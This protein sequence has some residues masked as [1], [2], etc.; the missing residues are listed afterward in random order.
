MS[1]EDDATKSVQGVPVLSIIIPVLNEEDNVAPLFERLDKTLRALANDYEVI[2][3][4]DGSTDQTPHRIKALAEADSHVRLVRLRRNFGQTA[5]LM[6][7]FDTSVGDIIIPLDGD[8]QNDPADIPRL[9]DKMAEGYE[10][11]SGWRRLRRDPPLRVIASRIANSMISRISGVPLKDYGCTL[12]AYKRSVVSELKLYGE[13]HRFIPIFSAWE[14]GRITE[15]PVNHDRRLRG[16]SKYGFGRTFPVILDLILIR[17]LAR[18]A[19]KPIH[20]FGAVGLFMML[21]AFLAGLYALWLKL[22][23]DISFISTPMPMLV[24]MLGML[25]VMSIMIG[26]L[27]EMILRTYYESQDKKPYSVAETVNLAEEQ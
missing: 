6:A 5:A 20:L 21:G 26:L 7:G 24:V 25:G 23:E 10:V 18:H 1:G 14:G 17:Y 11:V 3:V 8:G 16:R 4:D 13:L 12:K 2:F 15:I 27:A 19:T 9:L 22:A